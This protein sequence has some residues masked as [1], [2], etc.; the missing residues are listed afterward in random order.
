VWWQLPGVVQLLL[1][2][3]SLKGDL[4]DA[5]GNLTTLEVRHH[6]VTTST[7]GVC[8]IQVPSDSHHEPVWDAV[9]PAW[10]GYTHVAQQMQDLE[11]GTSCCLWLLEVLMM[12]LLLYTNQAPLPA[13]CM[14]A[15]CSSMR[16]LCATICRL[17]TTLLQVLQLGNNQLNGTLPASWGG[18]VALTSLTLFQN[19]LR[20]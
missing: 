20:G 11:V 10:V 7:V 2:G 9:D 18:M 1:G 3:N 17:A 16:T 8:M 19:P 6:N 15:A 14:H 12:W 4:P 5:W 13:P